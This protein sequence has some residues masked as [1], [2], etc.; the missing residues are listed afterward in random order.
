MVLGICL[1]SSFAFAS[2]GNGETFSIETSPQYKGTVISDAGVFGTLSENGVDLLGALW[3]GGAGATGPAGPTGPTGP[4]GATGPTGPTGPAGPANVQGTTNA[5]AGF[6]S[7]LVA[8]AGSLGVLTVLG[9]VTD[10]GFTI[11]QGQDIA[12]AGN[13]STLTVQ[14][15]STFSGVTATG[16]TIT[17]GQ[18]IADAGVFGGPV[19]GAHYSQNVGASPTCGAYA[20]TTNTFDGGCTVLANSTDEAGTFSILATAHTSSIPNQTPMI[21][22]QPGTAWDAG[23]SCILQ[24]GN[25]NTPA[26]TAY[27]YTEMDAG[28]VQ[29]L[30]TTTYTTVSG[31]YVWHYVCG[32]P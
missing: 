21:W 2:S 7:S 8:D 20:N 27:M 30:W 9:G 25:L 18:I 24:S 28:G 6:F 5:D 31:P 19:T 26:G 1:F 11:T 3:D 15:A 10:T 22:L 29:I 14:G 13:F 12:D 32:G 23:Y 4:Q 17:R 16:F